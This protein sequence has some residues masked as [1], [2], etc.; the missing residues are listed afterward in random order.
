MAIQTLS[1]RGID[2]HIFHFILEN[3][4]DLAHTGI[5]R[6]TNSEVDPDPDLYST[7]SGS[8]YVHFI[9]E[10]CLDLAPQ[11]YTEQQTVR[12]IQIQTYTR[13]RI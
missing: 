8:G 13:N 3:C 6:A 1:A 4:L 7:G 5:Y 10:N 9:L 2:L 11:E 12:W